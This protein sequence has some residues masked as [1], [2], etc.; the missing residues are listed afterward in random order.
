MRINDKERELWVQNDEGLY[1]DCRRWRRQNKGGVRGYIRTHRAEIDA[2]IRAA[3][4]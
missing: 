1:L 3:L 2:V 4:G